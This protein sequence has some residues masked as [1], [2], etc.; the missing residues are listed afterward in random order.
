MSLLRV[1]GKAIFTGADIFFPSPRGPRLLIY[2]QIGTGVGRQMEV[3]ASDFEWHLG[4]L[5]ANREV[6][7]LE[8][9]IRRWDEPNSDRLV[10]LTFDDGYE[11]TYTTAFPLLRERGL[12]F[13]LYLATEMIDAGVS[14]GQ[15]FLTW[16]QVRTMSNSGLLTIGAHTHSHRDLRSVGPEETRN[17]LE[18]SNRLIEENV[19]TSPRHF[20]YPWGYWSEKA[21]QLVRQRYESAVLGAPRRAVANAD[22]H[23]IHRFPVQLSDGRFWFKHR[24]RGGLIMEERARRRLRGY[25]GP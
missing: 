14:D 11:D 24:L 4:W 19:G 1:A 6:I 9:A 5:M 17:E 25:T 16:E 8:S 23:Q 10:V 18:T 22:S 12:P 20:A 2:H 15:R 7:D 3:T 13:T 21:D